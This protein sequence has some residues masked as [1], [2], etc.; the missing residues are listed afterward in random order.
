[1]AGEI[2]LK[3]PDLAADGVPLQDLKPDIPVAG[4][5]EGQPLA[6]V[7]TAEAHV[8]TPLNHRGAETGVQLPDTVSFTGGVHFGIGCRS[9]LT[10]GVN[11]P[12]TGPQPY[13]FEAIAQINFI[14]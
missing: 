5:F 10:I 6:V 8:N 1:M 13:D 11:T 2:K 7:A 4:H 14:F 12:I 9:L 3:G